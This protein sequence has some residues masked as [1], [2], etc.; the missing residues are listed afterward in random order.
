M[1]ST[2][3]WLRITAANKLPLPYLGYVELDIQVIGVTIQGSGFLIVRDQGDEEADQTLQA[4][5]A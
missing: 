2:V 3:K 1:H 4:L 5:L